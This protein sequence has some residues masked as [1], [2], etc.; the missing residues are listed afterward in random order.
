MANTRNF[1]GRAQTALAAAMASAY[2]L[3]GN[4]GSHRRFNYA[5]MGDAANLGSRLEGANKFYG[6]TILVG[7]NT[8]PYMGIA[9]TVS[10]APLTISAGPRDAC[11]A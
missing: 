6:T 9:T 7:N 1:H 3:I 11:R 8:S 2:L 10:F 4:I 5:A